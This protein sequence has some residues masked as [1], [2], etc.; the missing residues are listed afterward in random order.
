MKE[1]EHQCRDSALNVPRV[2]Q[3][4]FME[5]VPLLGM[6]KV[7]TDTTSRGLSSSWRDKAHTQE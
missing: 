7:T 2:H 6:K 1:Q 4:V 3:Q 5:D